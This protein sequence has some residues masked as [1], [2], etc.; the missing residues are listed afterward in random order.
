MTSKITTEEA[1]S[2][3]SELVD[4][5][6]SKN[7]RFVIERDGEPAAVILSLADFLQTIA[8]T[9]EWVRNVQAEIR[10]KGLDHFTPE[11]IDGEIAAA[12]R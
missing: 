4:R 10:R 6:V 5:A 12:R 3:L 11:D 2:Q 7:E 8:P 1:G 9:P